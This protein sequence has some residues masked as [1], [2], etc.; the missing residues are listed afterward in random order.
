MNKTPLGNATST[1]NDRLAI[2]FTVR[3]ALRLGID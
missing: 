3:T 2:K 1:L